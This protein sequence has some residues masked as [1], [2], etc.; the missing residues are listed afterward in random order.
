MLFDCFSYF[1]NYHNLERMDSG[2]S[3]SDNPKY[4]TTKYEV[5]ENVFP[6]P[7]KGTVTEQTPIAAFQLLYP[8]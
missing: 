7:A 6:H 8:R 2:K 4:Y 5:I 1:L 3:D